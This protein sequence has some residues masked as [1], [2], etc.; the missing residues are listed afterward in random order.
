MEAQQIAIQLYQIG[1]IQFGTFTLKSGIE[2][3]IYLDLRRV[4]SS[5][6]LLSQIADAMWQEVESCRFDVVCGV[7]YTALPIATAFSLQH[8]TP[9]VMRR[10]EAKDYGTK[11]MIEGVFTEGQTCLVL[12][13]L[14]TSGASIFETIE[15]L[16]KAGLTV[17]DVVVLIDR[18]QGGK[19]RLAH[20]GY[21]LHSVFSLSFLLATLCEEGLIEKKIV[22]KVQEFIANNTFQ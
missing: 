13:D 2:S 18:E 3:P 21:R 5:P 15:P 8:G 6:E 1:A 4:V 16:E 17:S 19:A 11:K 7:P 22:A 12:E 10:K 14:I 9:M 20:A